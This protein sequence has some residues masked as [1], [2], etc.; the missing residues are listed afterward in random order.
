MLLRRMEERTARI[1]VVPT[2]DV[3]LAASHRNEALVKVTSRSLLIASTRSRASSGVLPW[4]SWPMSWPRQQGEIL[5]RAAVSLHQLR[6]T[7]S[8]HG[9][10]SPLQNRQRLL[11]STGGNLLH[12][13]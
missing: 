4:I 9:I 7:A 2:C 12:G 10:R 6:T 8:E 1:V 3:C 13:P 11:D 5:V